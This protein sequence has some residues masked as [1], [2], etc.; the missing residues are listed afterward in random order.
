M[1]RGQR[2][3]RLRWA[4]QRDAGSIDNTL[5]S[6]I[7]GYDELYLGI[8]VGTDSE[9]A[10]RVQLGSVPFSMQAMTVPDGSITT[11]KIAHGAVTSTKLSVD[12]GLHVSGSSDP[13][14]VYSGDSSVGYQTLR[15]KQGTVSSRWGVTGSAYGDPNYG[16]GNTFLDYS[17]SLKLKPSAGPDSMTIT[18]GGNVGIGTTNPSSELHA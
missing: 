5:A 7:E 10:P 16:A 11:A 3:G 17:G 6:A 12:N 2:S 8:T 18:Q 15:V 1:D 4:V 14:L 9:M 13:F